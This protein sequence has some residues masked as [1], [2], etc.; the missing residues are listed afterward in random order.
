MTVRKSFL[1]D[2]LG[3]M[4]SGVAQTIVGHPFDTCKVFLQTLK[5]FPPIAIFLSSQIYRGVSYPMVCS[6]VIASSTFG[7]NE[8]V[9]HRLNCSHF[10]SGFIAG[11]CS[12]L[13]VT[14]TEYCKVSRQVRQPIVL[15][16]LMRGF[17]PTFWRESIAF[18]LYFGLYR[19][20]QTE[21]GYQPLLHGGIAGASCWLVTYP[22]DTAKTR[23]QIGSHTTTWRALRAGKLFRGL[24]PCL[25]RSFVANACGF[26]VYENF[27]KRFMSP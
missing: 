16:S 22:L 20:L 23:V 6:G 15:R 3:G 1:S 2:F 8:Y 19:W 25:V 9:A 27:K 4:A 10:Y 14:P 12:S 18:S 7:V 21:R 17:V 24:L 26:Y 13:L 11:A 5:T